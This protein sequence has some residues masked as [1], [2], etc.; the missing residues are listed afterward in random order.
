MYNQDDDYDYEM[1]TRTVQSFSDELDYRIKIEGSLERVQYDDS[2]EV[3]E[4]IQ[5]GRIK[6]IQYW[7]ESV[8]TGRTS[9]W[10]L[11]DAD[12]QEACEIYE[13]VFDPELDEFKLK[14]SERVKDTF[15]MR[16]MLY[17]HSVEILPEFRGKGIGLQAM[18]KFLKAHHIADGLT[19]TCP[20]PMNPQVREWED[21]WSQKMQ[22]DQ[23]QC[24]YEQAHAKLAKHWKQVGFLP[25]PDSKW[26]I[27]YSFP[28]DRL[29][30]PLWN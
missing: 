18:R 9:V 24:S 13:E 19:V 27:W 15:L 16:N 23:F 2:G 29:P 1:I 4:R 3:V 26:H 25:I 12:S 30:D 28:E 7:L 6:A 8:I 22:Y 11:L 5:V 21:D 17:I 10:D 14:V 20:A